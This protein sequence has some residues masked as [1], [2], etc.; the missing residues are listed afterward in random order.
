MK[1][2]AFSKI[3][4]E[5]PEIQL[6]KAIG[7]DRQVSV[8]LTRNDGANISRSTIQLWRKGKAVI[9][10]WAIQQLLGIAIKRD[11]KSIRPLLF[12]FGIFEDEFTKSRLIPSHWANWKR[13]RR[14]G[15]PMYSQLCRSR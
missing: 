7:T 4:T 5:P 1:F 6:L 10:S 12:R 13:S 15:K 8:L 11:D 3:T 2:S 14:D 9:P